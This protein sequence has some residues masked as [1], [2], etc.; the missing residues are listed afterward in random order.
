MAK[1]TEAQKERHRKWQKAYRE[2]TGREKVL[3][4]KKKWSKE[5]PKPYK[6]MGEK[7][8]TAKKRYEAKHPERVKAAK[9]AYKATLRTIRRHIHMCDTSRIRA[10]HC[11]VPHSLTKDWYAERLAAGVCELSGIRFDMIGIRTP[12]SP[13]TDRIDAEGPYSPENCRVI[14]WWL[15]RAL[16]DNGLELAVDIFRKVIARQDAEI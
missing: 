5:H 14:I 2:G 7:E 10:A 1:K 9:K 12:F 11:G 15:N 16:S 4:A 8:Y 3:A 6:K 13:S